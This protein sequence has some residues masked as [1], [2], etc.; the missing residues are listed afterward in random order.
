M[1]TAVSAAVDRAGSRGRTPVATQ[2]AKEAPPFRPA[3]TAPPGPSQPWASA[4][5]AAAGNAGAA[6]G[7]LLLLAILFTTAV[8]VPPRTLGRLLDLA[9]GTGSIGYA[10]V[11]H[12]PG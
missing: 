9:T 4:I 5:A 12:R 1:P 7:G 11:V 10:Q 8:A 6:L 2:A 3:P